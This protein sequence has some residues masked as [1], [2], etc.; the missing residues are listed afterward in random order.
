MPSKKSQKSSTKGPFFFFMMEYKSK[1]E[2]AGRRFT[3]GMTEVMQK[4]GPHW[5][6]LAP[7]EREPYNIKAKKY[8]AHPTDLIGERYTSQGIAFSQVETAAQARRKQE[9]ET[10]KT[11]VDIIQTAVNDNSLE[12][13][14]IFLIS[15]NYFCVTTSNDYVPAELAL[16]KYSLGKGIM[17]KMN[18]LINPQ[19]LPLGMAH[20]A[21]LHTN[22]THQL[23][24]PPN[25]IGEIDY[26][27]VLK[28]IFKFTAGSSTKRHLPLLFTYNKDQ[29]MVKNILLGFLDATGIENLEPRVYPLVD[30]FFYLK[31]ATETYGLD[32][33]TFP[34]VHMAKALLEKDV[35]AYT[36]G[37]GCEVHE[38]LGNTVQ[39]ALSRCIRWAYTISDS[40]CLDLG[41]E[42]EGGKHL[43]DNM[44]LPVD[45]TETVTCISSRFDKSVN[46]TESN[47]NG[48]VRRPRSAERKHDGDKTNTTIYSSRIGTVSENKNCFNNP[49][50]FPTIRES[51][52]ATNPFRNFNPDKEDQNKME[53]ISKK[54]PW[55]RE[56][57]LNEARVPLEEQIPVVGR[58]RGTLATLL[59]GRGK[60]METFASIKSFGRGNLN[61]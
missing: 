21:E 31:Q 41:I 1:E 29:V 32:I 36:L 22:E 10:Q 6:K 14:E 55:S 54:N 56:L 26:E 15:C 2:A 61:Y 40:C 50:D 17:D 24:L 48:P 30:L 5:E 37:I 13:L 25:A 59:G 19:E 60:C 57:K 12:Q 7:Y 53:S 42:M 28:N 20:D 43:P 46:V 47:R 8:K 39:C 49:R 58:G 38:G 16:I 27:K 18:I 44:T 51:F 23:P 11:I 33:C 45:V 3:G 52:N 34:S 9:I 35:Y 4:A